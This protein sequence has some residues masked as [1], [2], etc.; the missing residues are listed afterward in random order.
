MYL[1]RLEIQGFKSFADKVEFEFPSGI[2]AIVG[3]NGSGK[4]NV[5]DSIRWVLGE[6]SIKNLRGSKMEDVIFAGSADRR[7]L[8]MAQVSLTLD[9]SSR[10]FDLDFEEV[11]VSRRLYR[12]G[13]SEYLINKASS[14]LKD[15]QELFMDTGLGREGLSIISQGKVDEILSLKPED[16][17]GLIEEAAGITRYKYRK[18]EAE[19]KLKDTEDNLVRV[20]DIVQELAERVEP[21]GEQA[22]K[23][24][25]YREC[26]QE[27]DKLE[28]SLEVHDIA[29]NKVQEQQL[30]SKQRQME[31][32]LVQLAAGLSGQE[33]ELAQLRLEAQQEESQF[34][35]QQQSYYDLQNRLERRNNTIHADT[36]LLA[37]I[38]EQM[39]RL[40]AEL[41][42]QQREAA[43]L[44]QDSAAK[45]QQAE[46]AEQL[47]RQQQTVVLQQEQE[48]GQLDQQL[49]Q[50]MQQQE[51]NKAAV[52]ANMQAQAR[53][54]NTM[55]R[56]EHELSGGD[57][58]RE[59]TEQKLQS[60]SQALQEQQ[61]QSLELQEQFQQQQEAQQAHIKTIAVLEREVV[62]RKQ[63]QFAMRQQLNELQASWQEQQS[64][65]K[66]LKELED[67]GEGY[68]YGVKSVLE[69]KNR[70]KLSGI[71]GT[72][73]QLIRV[74]R[75]L[76]KAIETTMGVSL[77]NLVTEDDKQAQAA[78]QYLKERKK[79][80][81]TFLPLNT[82]KGQRPEEDLSNEE[83]V[84]G[85]AVDLIEFDSKYEN[86]LLHLLGKVW[87]IADLPS[88]VA[89]GKKRGFSHRMVTLDG[90]LVTPGGALTGGNH[91][92]ERSSLLARQR[93]ILELE[94][95]VQQ[96]AEQMEQQNQELDAYYIVTGEKKAAITE[97]HSQDQE[98]IR[99]T[100]QLEQQ[101][102]QQ[103]REEQRL[104]KEISFEQ[105][106]LQ[107]QQQQLQE[108]Q[109]ALEQEIALLNT[110]AVT[111]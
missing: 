2:T 62:Q 27:L 5:V 102:T 4:S 100:A 91:E 78:I 110:L 54:H 105:F 72:V 33:A 71:I 7:P 89:I 17:R 86:I 79:G 22:E 40:Q 11:T 53:N 47:F 16:R 94:Q 108:Q 15:I 8:G 52:F 109:A 10:L 76:E 106:S 64:K 19:R 81:A 46:E 77:Q 44:L 80:R 74:P 51:E 45:Q 97:L 87:V 93:Q 58:S 37:N 20:Q 50:T 36:Q 18:R 82:V 49:Q 43:A 29:R 95:S 42:V 73:S 96:L 38:V 31:D 41:A 104:Q 35:Q 28:L 92:K 99:R 103:Q 57:R 9:N 12:S 66:A 24:K 88:A 55:Q 26:K 14:R 3:P 111:E 70:G 60:L 84:L 6:Q 21:L 98:L 67:S 65:A 63:Q 13:E 48:L 69:Q 25:Q 107:E 61:Q 83:N 85:L 75:H 90:E 39:Q 23:A 56:L 32:R 34:Q 101:L 1:K 59:K 68:Q 30:Q